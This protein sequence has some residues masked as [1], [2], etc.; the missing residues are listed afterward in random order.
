MRLP[1]MFILSA[2]L[3][4]CGSNPDIVNLNAATSER[5]IQY[6]IG[7]G[8]GLT[9]NVWNNPEVS[10]SV[11]VR[12]D[13]KITTPLVEDMQAVG[14]TPKQLARD[15]EV[16]LADFVRSP[17][18][19]V[20]VSGFVG[21][22]SEQVRVIGQAAQPQALSYRDRMTLLD[23]MIE[24]GGLGPNAAGNR[25]KIVRWVDETQTEI[26]VKI[27]N[28][29]NKGRIRENVLMLPGDILI[30]PEARF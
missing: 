9:I 12:P 10:A 26:P 5:D 17:K 2:F 29:I 19:S 11:S 6:L 8:D 21:T 18:V 25:A 14:K 30:I 15:I 23:V 27:D 20:I 1:V 16:V 22:Y 13:G 28:L 24:V 3:V 4:A 7:P